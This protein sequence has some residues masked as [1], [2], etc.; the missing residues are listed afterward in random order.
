MTKDPVVIQIADEKELVTVVP[1]LL[2]FHPTDS[3]VLVTFLKG[4]NRL[5]PV[6]RIDLTTYQADMEGVAAYLAGSAGRHADR[7]VLVFYG[8]AS[9]PTHLNGKLRRFGMPVMDTLFVDNE[10]IELHA[11]LQAE[12]V[13][14]G[15][16]VAG[17]RED[18]RA[19]VEFD[20]EDK[21]DLNRDLLATMIDPVTRDA[22]V[23]TLLEVAE[24]TLDVVL[25]NCRRALD[26]EPGMAD[27]CAV[28]AILAY[29]TGDGA[30]A[31]VCLDRALRV[32]PHH[33]LTRLTLDLI[34]CAVSPQ[35]L[36][37]L[38]RDLPP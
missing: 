27:L 26:D 12:Y 8:L 17:T 9:D 20:S 30:L 3:I 22:Y 13:A 34:E 6:I 18:L 16:A 33:R 19:K 32:D 36:D 23:T 7:C 5:G 15:K 29:R 11:A 35:E 37:A 28:A 25:A 4:T 10:P 21:V 2:G 38:V 14:L 1:V 31:Q 24:E